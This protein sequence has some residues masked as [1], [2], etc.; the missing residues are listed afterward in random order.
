MTR[1]RDST[2]VGARSPRLAITLHGLKILEHPKTKPELWGVVV[3]WV[4]VHTAGQGGA[5]TAVL[6]YGEDGRLIAPGFLRQW[7]INS[8]GTGYVIK[9][10]V[11]RARRHA[12]RTG[13]FD[14]VDEERVTAA[15]RV[16]MTFLAAMCIGMFGVFGIYMSLMV[17]Q[18][19]GQNPLLLNVA[20][21]GLAVVMLIV[22]AMV[23]GGMAWIWIRSGWVVA[24]A[25]RVNGER[26]EI[27]TRDGRVHTYP[28]ADVRKLSIQFVHFAVKTND[29]Q[30]FLV[31]PRRSRFVFQEM[32][33][34]QNPAAAER[35]TERAILRMIFWWFQGG[36]AVIAMVT[37]WINAAGLGP[38]PHHPLA[39]YGVAGFGV[40]ALM[41]FSVLGP[42]AI[43][44]WDAGR[45]RRKRSRERMRALGQTL[46]IR[47]AE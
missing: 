42:S 19:L 23:F 15:G 26:I 5:T 47:Q 4:R 1:G 31:M 6:L 3:P 10:M 40:P 41:A 34:R 17:L 33:K 12:L 13:A 14:I 8:M 44:K 24:S 46:P 28:W 11:D 16:G 36:G 7:S 29:G 39:Y 32:M 22:A 37:M 45:M 2:N 18:G 21:V 9:R 43:A 20:C 30:T 27:T 25:L 38:A 35:N